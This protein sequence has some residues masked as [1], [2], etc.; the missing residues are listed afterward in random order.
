MIAIKDFLADPKGP[1]TG[2]EY[3]SL[4]N[5]GSTTVSLAGWSI[6]D[7]S[8]K[9]FVLSGYS[10]P[11]GKQL[12][13]FSSATK[14]TIN[15]SSEAISLFDASGKLVDELVLSGKAIEG[16]PFSRIT[17]LTKEVQAKLFDASIVDK[18]PAYQPAMS[19]VFIVWFVTAS[20]L[21][22]AAVLVMRTIKEDA[23]QLSSGGVDEGFDF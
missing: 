20:L 14:I 23:V 13:L 18:L 15:N 8:G 9:T 10:L 6:K 17:T 16:Q 12:R 7:K 3:I 21:A 2:A 5:N 19:Q 22:L 1:D 11:A 4:I